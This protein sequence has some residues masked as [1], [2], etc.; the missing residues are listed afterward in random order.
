MNQFQFFVT[1]GH[2]NLYYEEYYKNN[3]CTAHEPERILHLN[4][5]YE[6]TFAARY[7]P[8]S[9]YD[10]PFYNYSLIEQGESK[11]F[12]DSKYF[13]FKPGDFFIMKK[14]SSIKYIN[15]TALKRR[16]VFINKHPIHSI[17]INHYF[18]DTINIIHF[19]NA[20]KINVILDQIKQA[21]STNKTD[22]LEGLLF[23]L[24]QTLIIKKKHTK[25]PQILCA[26]LEFIGKNEGRP[27]LNNEI[28]D[29]FKISTRTL[30]R[31]F[32]QYLHISPGEYITKQQLE[33]AKDL[34]SL[35]TMQIKEV[36]FLCGFSS[37]S[38]FCRR[39]KEIYGI[40]PKI[41]KKNMGK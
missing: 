34:L 11:Q 2:G 10:F 39:F 3:P 4:A 31:L 29:N 14:A 36:A 23:Q 9:V 7:Q 25:H 28:A 38:Y 1:K 6:S 22:F 27:Y 32:H 12:I 41:F 19:S 33:K 30:T 20:E 15:K 40:T 16:G 26:V 21:V 8:A 13:H 24:I 18:P 35:P 37:S 17:M 5:Y